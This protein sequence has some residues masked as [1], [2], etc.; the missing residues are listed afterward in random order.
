MIRAAWYVLAAL[1]GAATG[2]A[3]LTVLANLENFSLYTIRSLVTG[4]RAMSEIVNHPA[5]RWVVPVLL[6]MFLIGGAA[7]GVALIK[8]S[9]RRRR[10]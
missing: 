5:D 2:F 8:W 10:T 6:A 4:K 3:G 1:A 7:T 9:Y